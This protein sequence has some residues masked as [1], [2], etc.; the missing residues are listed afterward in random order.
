[1]PRSC[2]C[3]Q[4]SCILKS[5]RFEAV[6]LRCAATSSTCSWIG[7][8]PPYI[9]LLSIL[10]H[11]G[12]KFWVFHSLCQECTQRR[13]GWLQAWISRETC[14]GG[15]IQTQHSRRYKQALCCPQVSMN[16]VFSG[17]VGY[18]GTAARSSGMAFNAGV[19]SAACPR[20][21]WKLARD[22]GED[23]S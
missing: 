23:E 5:I 6:Y 9:K 4:Q 1:M 13:S 15:Q 21:D 2:L 18:L 12:P 11:L 19:G 14:C 3:C 7:L 8:S 22:C 17:Q 10:C 20:P 16:S